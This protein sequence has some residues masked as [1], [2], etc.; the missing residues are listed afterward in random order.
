MGA[1]RLKAI[2]VRGTHRVAWSDTPALLAAAKDLSQR[3][4]G[5]ATAKYREVGTAANLL[6]LN[7]L[8]AL[9]TRNFQQSS[10]TR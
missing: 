10:S 9:P 6:V 1:K 3:S 5:P 7:R 4:L 2:A 8:H